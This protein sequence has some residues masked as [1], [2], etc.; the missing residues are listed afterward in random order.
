MHLFRSF[1]TPAAL[2]LLAA[3]ALMGQAVISA[4]RIAVPVGEQTLLQASMDEAADQPV[5]EWRSSPEW[6]GTIRADAAG[7]A[8]FMAAPFVLTAEQVTI[9]AIPGGDFSKAATTT[10]TVVHQYQDVETLLKQELTGMLGTAWFEPSM[11][12]LAGSMEASGNAL[13]SGT[14]ARFFEVEGITWVGHHPDPNLSGKWLVCHEHGLRVLTPEG[15]VRHWEGHGP[16]QAGE[17]RGTRF[18]FS[19]GATAI[20]VKP[21]PAGAEAQWEAVIADYMRA[22]IYRMD[23]RGQVTILAGV[24]GE[25]AHRDGPAAEAL[26]STPMGVTYGLDGAVYVTDSSLACIR[27]IHEGQVT[28]IAGH[29]EHRGDADGSGPEARFERNYG[30]ALDPATGNLIVGDRNRLRE[31]TPAGQ[32]TTLAGAADRGFEEWLEAPPSAN[33]GR[34]RMAGIACLASVEGLAVSRG[35]VFMADQLNNAIRVLDLGTGDLTT[36]VG[37]GRSEAFR[38]GPIGPAGRAALNL[39]ASL[40]APRGIALN[41]FGHCLVTAGLE[42]S[43]Q[44]FGVFELSLDRRDRPNELPAANL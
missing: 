36:L 14:A 28:T 33:L 1:L 18:P 30:I 31:V 23:A 34:T 10:I 8:T 6:A 42:S 17:L 4:H 26:F 40:K 44:G 20:A 29:P 2:A 12:L 39:G 27:R 3:P 5:W 32:V 19:R 37:D 13:G 38:E 22:V 16:A 41:P 43:G 15:E 21:I 25:R 35:Q 11:G 7:V 9:Q 24:A